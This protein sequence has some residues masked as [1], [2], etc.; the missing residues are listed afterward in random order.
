MG[1]LSYAQALGVCKEAQRMVNSASNCGA[2]V[3]EQTVVFSPN[4]WKKTKK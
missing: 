3:P 1:S 2:P 4:N